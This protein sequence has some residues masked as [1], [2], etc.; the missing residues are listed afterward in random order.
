MTA[1]FDA[2]RLGT[3]SHCAYSVE[4]QKSRKL[5]GTVLSVKY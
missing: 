4:N 5:H 2:C 1:Q 3:K